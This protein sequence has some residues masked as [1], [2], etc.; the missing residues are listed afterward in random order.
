MNYF[1]LTFNKE[2]KNNIW[3]EVLKTGMFFFHQRCIQCNL[4]CC[5][6]IVTFAIQS[7][8][9]KRMCANYLTDRERSKKVVG[10]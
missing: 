8:R 5:K 9:E 4:I 7:K 2:K 3:C 6:L 10:R 1:A